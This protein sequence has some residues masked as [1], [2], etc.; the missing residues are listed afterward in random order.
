MLLV[1]YL[2]TKVRMVTDPE[3]WLTTAAVAQ[4]ELDR[5]VPKSLE[6]FWGGMQKILELLVT[7]L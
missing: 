7:K 1:R 3:H 5:V 6:W 2:V 4:Y